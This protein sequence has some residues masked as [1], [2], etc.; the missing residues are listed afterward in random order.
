MALTRRDAVATLL[1]ALVVAVFLA[2]HEGWN[3]WL[4]GDSHRW[5]AAAI[6]VLGVA[7]C[8]LG[9][10][11]AA[12]SMALGATAGVLSIVALVTGSLTALSLLVLADVVL[13]LVSLARHAGDHAALPA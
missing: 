11:R 9:T 2:T 8:A 6:T 10:S 7:T 4:V 5:A 12:T 3:V 1:T 13:W